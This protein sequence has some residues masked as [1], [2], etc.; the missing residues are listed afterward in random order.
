M[1]S[2]VPAP[3][4]RA[5]RRPM[6]MRALAAVAAAATA[7]MVGLATP[8]L[9]AHGGASRSPWSPRPRR[10]RSAREAPLQPTATSNGLPGGRGERRFD[11]SARAPA[12]SS[13]PFAQDVPTAA[14]YNPH[15]GGR[16]S[17]TDFMQSATG[18][19]ESTLAVR[20]T[21]H[22][23]L[24]V[25]PPWEAPRFDCVH[26]ESSQPPWLRC[27][28]SSASRHWSCGFAGFGGSTLSATT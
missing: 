15:S 28:H 12:T 9:A 26:P 5:P 27:R 17:S 7:T 2:S 4:D 21:P 16:F 22:K 20:R 24:F 6:P 19:S 11:G 25:I 10:S 13:R 1:L 8:A 14:R 3:D 23:V 18:P